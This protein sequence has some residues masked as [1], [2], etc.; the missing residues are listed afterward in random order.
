MNLNSTDPLKPIK[1]LPLVNEINN[2]FQKQTKSK[3]AKADLLYYLLTALFC[4][5]IGFLFYSYYQNEGKNPLERVALSIFSNPKSDAKDVC[6]CYKNVIANPKEAENYGL[7][8]CMALSAEK[9]LKYKEKPKELLEFNIQLDS[10]K[11]N[12]NGSLNK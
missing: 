7:Q 6:D 3:R 4:V 11:F 10:C 8:K 12:F 1:N 5:V 9:L 2:D